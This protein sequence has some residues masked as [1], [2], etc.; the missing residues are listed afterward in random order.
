MPPMAMPDGC[1]QSSV[2]YWNRHRLLIRK[3]QARPGGVPGG[4]KARDATPT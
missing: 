1:E 2:P 4:L 3:D